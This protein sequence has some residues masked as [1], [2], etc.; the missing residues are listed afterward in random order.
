MQSKGFTKI[1]DSTASNTYGG[2]GLLLL[3][4][5]LPMIIPAISALATSFKVLF[6]DKGEV[7]TK[8]GSTSKWETYEDKSSSLNKINFIN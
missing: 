4:T 3:G 7:K 6:S 8:D 1:S 5:L 2:S